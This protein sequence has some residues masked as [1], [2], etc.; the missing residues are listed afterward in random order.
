MFLHW[1]H[2][3]LRPWNSWWILPSQS[4]LDTWK[5]WKLCNDVDLTDTVDGSEIPNNH[6]GMVLNKTPVNNGDKI[7][8]PTSTWWVDP[9]YLNH[10][11]YQLKDLVKSWVLQRYNVAIASRGRESRHLE[12]LKR[13]LVKGK[14]RGDGTGQ[15]LCCY[16]ALVHMGVSRKMVGNPHF[17]PQSDHF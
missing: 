8:P 2:R 16:I 9:G 14:M 12:C 13:C 4:I 6:H 11:Q 15:P 7:K 3:K 5:L 17:T 1:Q 10:Q